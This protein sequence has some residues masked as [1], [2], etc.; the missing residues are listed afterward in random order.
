M[1]AFLMQYL[2]H[3][4]QSWLLVSYAARL[5][6]ALNYH[7]IRGPIQDF[8]TNEEA[9]SC[10]YW[11]YCFDR[12]LSALLRRPVSL[13]ALQISPVDLISAEAT[14]PHLPLIRI[15]MNLAQVQGELLGCGKM[16]STRQEALSLHTQLQDRMA[17]IRGSLEVVSIFASSRGLGV[18]F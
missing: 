12:T 5:L 6:T 16:T 7:E 18:V 4:N 9:Y 14:M 17:F 3:M 10:L 8:D 1:Q 15:I 11:C 13:P 2:G